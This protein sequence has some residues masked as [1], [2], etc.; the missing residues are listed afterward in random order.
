[1]SFQNTVE[2][3]TAGQGQM[4]GRSVAET[5]RFSMRGLPLLKRGATMDLLGNGHHMWAHAKVYSTGGENALH[6]HETEDHLFF[7]LSGKAV[8]SFGDESSFEALPFEGVFLPKGT[9]YKF[10]ADGGENL[11]LIRV[12]AAVLEHPE[13]LDDTFHVPKELIKTRRAPDGKFADGSAK[14]N[15]AHSEPVEYLPGVHFAG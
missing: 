12:G 1:M 9:Q 5:V 11:V 8:F 6:K 14:N 13:D 3:D 10:R 4:A 7:V 2:N 15:G